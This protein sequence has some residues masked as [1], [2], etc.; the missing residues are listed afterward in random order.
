MDAPKP[1]NLTNHTYW[2]LSGNM[3]ASILDHVL[4][5]NCPSVLP[6]DDTKIPTGEQRSVDGSA[7]DCTATTRAGSRIN[8]VDGGGGSRATTIATSWAQRKS[9][10]WKVL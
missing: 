10:R 8:D 6:V 2:N 1:V 4:R 3:S 7:M 5:L 9:R